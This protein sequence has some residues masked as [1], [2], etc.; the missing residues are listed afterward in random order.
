ML[1][2]Q[3]R[4]NGACLVNVGTAVAR[5]GSGQQQFIETSTQVVDKTEA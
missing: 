1:R 2:A 4:K 3:N 5:V